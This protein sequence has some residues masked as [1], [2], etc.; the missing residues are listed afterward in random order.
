MALFQPSWAPHGNGAANAVGFFI[1]LSGF[2]SAFSSGGKTLDVDVKQILPYLWRK[3]KKV[4]PL[5]ALTTLM[6]IGYSSIPALVAHHNASDLMPA[7]I[8]L[9]KCLLLIQSWWPSGYFAF[10]GVGWF[11]STIMFLYLLNL[12]LRWLA[13]R[14]LQT[15]RSDAYFMLIAICL[16]LLITLYCYITRNT[17]TEFTQY[18]L[19][20]SRLPEYIIGMC[21]GYV[22]LSTR[23]RLG[24]SNKHVRLDG[25]VL[26]SIN[27][28]VVCT[29]L[30]LGALGLWI[31][32]MYIPFPDWRFRIVEWLI[33]NSV[34][35]FI[36][37]LG[38]GLIARLFEQPVLRW[39]G[40]IS[41]ECFLIH[42]VLITIYAPL[43]GVQPTSKLGSLFMILFCLILTIGLSALVSRQP[44]KARDTRS[45]SQ[46][47]G[48]TKSAHVA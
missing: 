35:V 15:R 39:L 8:Q 4:Y 43:S 12:P 42:Q 5:Y 16:G 10:N 45:S 9:L 11:L 14:I 21:L 1:L 41:F 30:E 29:I 19:P 7:L 34:L 3:I 25:D 47:V 18:I 44:L 46:P 40:D 13:S 26:P 20:P 2:L 31:A 36:F 33:P 24:T 38:G 28:P 32:S 27:A 17:A 6:A 22:A 23:R 37:A 48:S